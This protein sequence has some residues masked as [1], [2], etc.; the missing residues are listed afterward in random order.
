MAGL[1][2]NPSDIQSVGIGLAAFLS[3]VLA[4]FVYLSARRERLGRPMWI[5]LAAAAMWSSF[6]F[7]YHIVGDV[8]LARGMRVL[9]VMGIVFI[10]MSELNF[11]LAYLGERVRTGRWALAAK[12]FVF[13]GGAFLT[14][15]LSID[16]LGGRTIVGD[17]LLPPDIAL[18]PEA[19]PLMIVLI[20]YYSCST[21]ISGALLAWRVRSA[22]DETDRKQALLLFVSMTI[23]LTLGALRFTPWYGFDF[24]PLLG[25]I[26]FP[27]FTFAALYS[28]KR[29]HLLNIQVI[30]AQILI[31]L[32]WTFTF[33][34]I[35]LDT[36][37]REAVPDIGLFIASVVLGILLLRS[38]IAEMRSQKELAKLTIDRAK[39]EFIT[40]AAHQ[41]RTPAAALRWSFNL[42]QES[43]GNLSQSQRAIVESGNRAADNM[44]HII[45]DLLDMGRIADGKFRY[46]FTSGDIADT[47]RT[48]ASLFKD[49]ADRKHVVF[50]LHISDMPVL[51]YDETKL[52]LAVQNLIDNA[53][54]YTP[55]GGT[56]TI[57]AASDDEGVR[58]TVSD[59]GI[60]F[61][62]DERE[63]VFEKFF[64][65]SRAMR[66]S[67]DG[68]GLG[69]VISKT[70]VEGHGGTMTFVSEEGKGTTFTILL[71][72]NR[73]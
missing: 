2:F 65:G 51:T 42:L 70:V 52:S 46:T 56:V 9:S 11:A 23:G 48:S 62:K 49:E 72:R 30:A 61:T 3:M 32:L 10:S 54:T 40:I 66:I 50:E 22:V 68:S 44:A 27:L 47:L 39:S 38:T 71:P 34:R 59:T 5:M 57:A 17:L 58:I 73:P 63:R 14:A 24:Y 37:I 67:P 29:Y 19:G 41:L 35:L 36:S 20:A 33:F 53:I 45:G 21:A 12:R 4:I 31:F 18:A 8:S 25:D 28:I 16:L 13:W 55:S 7:L 69:L 43:G 6:G 1:V 26:G 64:R 15:L 60:G